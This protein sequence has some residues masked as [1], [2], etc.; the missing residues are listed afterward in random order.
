[1][2]LTF[3]VIILTVRLIGNHAFSYNF[4]TIVLVTFKIALV[5]FKIALGY[6]SCNYAT[7]TSTIIPKFFVIVD[8][9]VQVSSQKLKRGGG[10]KHISGF[11]TFLRPHQN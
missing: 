8:K 11:N 6:A 4:G 3:T 2:C 10:L 7:V 9:H 1:M 5:T